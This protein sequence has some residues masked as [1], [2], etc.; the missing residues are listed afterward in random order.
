MR[1]ISPLVLCAGV[2][3]FACQKRS[4]PSAAGPRASSVAAAVASPRPS[5]SA[6]E[7][8]LPEDPVLAQRATAQW[9]EHMEEEETGRKLNYDRRKLTEHRAALILLRSTRESYD[10]AKTKAAVV[11]VQGSLPKAES[12][13]KKQLEAIDRWGVN[14][15][16][17]GDY[18]ELQRLLLAP[19]PAAR[20]AALSGDKAEFDAVSAQFDARLKK[21]NDWL[22][23]AAESKDE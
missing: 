3:L 6:E 19:Y 10:R 1:R 12:A 15:N 11:S 8:R 21:I 17:L 7:A 16:V 23:R 18:A 13:L 2:A 5:A 4:E 9:R 22:A 20:I 14:S